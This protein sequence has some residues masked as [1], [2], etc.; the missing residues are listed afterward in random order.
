MTQ[1]ALQTG[2]LKYFA[3]QFVWFDMETGIDL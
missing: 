1:G 2:E 3:L